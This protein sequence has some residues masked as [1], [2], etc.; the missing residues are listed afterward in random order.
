MVVEI[1]PFPSVE[2]IDSFS[3]SRQ[4]SAPVSKVTATSNPQDKKKRATDAA[5]SWSDGTEFCYFT[6]ISGDAPSAWRA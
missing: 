2:A 4:L 1:C 3:F 5:R 6:Q